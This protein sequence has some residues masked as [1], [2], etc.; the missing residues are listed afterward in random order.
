MYMT[1]VTT[2]TGLPPKRSPVIILVKQDKKGGIDGQ[3][4]LHSGAGH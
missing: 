1:M 4:E 3:E 2:M